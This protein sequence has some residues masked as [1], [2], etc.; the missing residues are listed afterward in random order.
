MSVAM[1]HW[2]HYNARPEQGPAWTY[3][4]Q[5]ATNRRS[6]D[7]RGVFS[8][9]GKR[10]MVAKVLLAQL[11]MTV[12]LAMLFWGTDGRVTGYSA[13]LGGLICVIPN[14]FLA[15]RL[16]VPRRDPGAGAL[17]RAA[18]IGELG[19]LALT[20]LMFGAVF[21]LVRPLAA[22][23]LFAGFI[24]AQLVTFSGFLMRDKQSEE[25]RDLKNG[26]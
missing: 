14:A 13:L 12:V 26:S 19:K 7:G 21:M 20:V 17:V 2:H 6:A 25:T 1:T 3:R 8:A 24:A 10:Q 11:G 5:S 22:T 16:A 23:A 18:Y 9:G 4:Y 15:L